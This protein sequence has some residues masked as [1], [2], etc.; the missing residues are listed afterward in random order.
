MNLHVSLH[1]SLRFCLYFIPSPVAV[2]YTALKSRKSEKRKD[3]GGQRE[4][5][6]HVALSQAVKRLPCAVC[7]RFNFSK[8]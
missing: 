8:L 1:G 5:L 4:R 3:E 2:I 6:T 7:S